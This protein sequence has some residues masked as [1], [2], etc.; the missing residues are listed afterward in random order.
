MTIIRALPS[1]G[2]S[3]VVRHFPGKV[4]DADGLLET[5]TGLTYGEAMTAI[6]R[7]PTLRATA[8][9]QANALGKKGVLLTNWSFPGMDVDAFVGYKPDDYIKHI[10]RYK[11]TDLIDAFGE[12]TLRLWAEDFD[13]NYDDCYILRP[14]QTLID[15]LQASRWKISSS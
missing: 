2:K 8:V 9:A 7:D 11:R 4:F 12:E 6:E 5:I 13:R 1:A 15:W 3:Y 10:K 14:D